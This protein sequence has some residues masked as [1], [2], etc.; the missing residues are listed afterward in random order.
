M[1][2]IDDLEY[3][4]TSDASADPGA[5]HLGCTHSVLGQKLADNRREHQRIGSTIAR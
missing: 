2:G 5:G 3:I 4:F 1:T